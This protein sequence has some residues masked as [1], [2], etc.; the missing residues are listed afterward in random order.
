MLIGDR[1]S[2]LQ[3][4]RR[5]SPR[6][7]VEYSREKAY[8][9]RLRRV[10]VTSRKSLLL[11][12]GSPLRDFRCHLCVARGG[13]DSTLRPM[14]FSRPPTLTA[15]AIERMDARGLPSAE[16]EAYCRVRML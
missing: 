10:I 3:R 15:P 11:A 7:T 4:G 12:T 6:H 16:T 8:P 9:R 13:I 5:T 14:T 2:Y 1:L